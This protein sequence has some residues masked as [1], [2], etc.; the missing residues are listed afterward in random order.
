[1]TRQQL[2]DTLLRTGP[3]SDA[4]PLTAGSRGKP[5]PPQQHRQLEESPVLPLAS[6][7]VRITESTKCCHMTLCSDRGSD[8]QSRHY[9]VLMSVLIGAGAGEL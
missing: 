8:P 1:M 4:P 7:F 9:G 2:Q 3:W 5:T 6:I